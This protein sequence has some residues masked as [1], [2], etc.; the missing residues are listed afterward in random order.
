MTPEETGF[1][2]QAAARITTPVEIRLAASGDG[3]AGEME[4]FLRALSRRLEHVRF[5]REDLPEGSPSAM[6]LPGGV[7]FLTVPGGA[8]LPPF[9]ESLAWIASNG[10][11]EKLPSAHRNLLDRLSVP[12]ALRLHISR[13]CPHC[14][15]AVSLWTRIALATSHLR[16]S[17]I[18]A[19]RYPEIVQRDKV[20]SV[21]TL[22]FDDVLRWTGK[23]LPEAVL[24]ALA[25]QDPA[26]LG[27][28]ALEDIIREGQA[29]GLARMMSTHR[30]I[31]P[32]LLDLLTHPKWPTRLGAMVVMETLAEENPGLAGEAAAQLLER[33]KNLDAQVKG[34]VLYLLG[35]AGREDVLPFVL[36][37]GSEA[38]DE[39][40]KTAAEEAADRIRERFL[41]AKETDP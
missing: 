16:L 24:P 10:Q 15:A 31:F 38:L 9:L 37:A 3:R 28:D 41:P 21:P 20:R 22:V 39:D 7:E 40:L 17:V 8:E 33:Y 13:K 6:K 1:I 25:D 30:R 23:A 27:A 4:T 35:E 2:D 29:A 26:R 34:D 11:G 12:C 19:E 36:A 5:R 18:E 32:A 14:P